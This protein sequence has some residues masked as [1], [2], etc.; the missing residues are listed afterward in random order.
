MSNQKIMQLIDVI[1]E[2]EELVSIEEFSDT[3]AK[4]LQDACR[5][6]SVLF[7]ALVLEIVNEKK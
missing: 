1:L 3:D 5:S 7:R 6:F 2:L 4:D